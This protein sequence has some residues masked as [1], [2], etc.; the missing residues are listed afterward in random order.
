[1]APPVSAGGIENGTTV[2][3]SMG[4][5][6]VLG[7]LCGAIVAFTS[8]DDSED[9]PYTRRGWIFGVGG[10]YAFESFDDAGKTH[11]RD[12]L[13]PPAVDYSA[14]DSFALT[15]GGGYRCHEYV[16]TEVGFE[17]FGS[18]GFDGEFEQSGFGKIADV[19]INGVVITVDARAY[20]PLGRFQP[21]ALIGP[22][23]MTAETK[24]QNDINV[25]TDEPA[26]LGAS[27]DAS[28]VV[29]LGGGID[30]Y[31]TEHLVVRGEAS[32]VIPTG[33]LHDFKYTSVGM[34]V[35]WR[36]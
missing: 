22:G 31:A 32:Y 15:G 19:D 5:S 25:H 12:E 13:E 4:G 3:Y 8:D 28:F 10:S 26:G 17:W 21:F 34:G 29:R 14:D 11:E 23:V 6:A 24:I 35:H 7:V 2:F 16:S 33:T 18:T 1:V 27:K 9:D 20:L 36:F 30:V